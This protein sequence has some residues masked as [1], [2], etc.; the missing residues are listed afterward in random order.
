M[1]LAKVSRASGLWVRLGFVKSDKVNS[2]FKLVDESSVI[3]YKILYKNTELSSTNFWY[4]RVQCSW[5]DE[6]SVTQ[7]GHA[8]IGLRNRT[9]DI[10]VQMQPSYNKRT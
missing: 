1:V 9:F 2:V 3:W 8:V 10:E 7:I 4:T 6:S 5:V